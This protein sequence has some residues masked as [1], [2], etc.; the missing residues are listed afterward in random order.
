MTI[1]NADQQER[2]R[3]LCAAFG[4]MYGMSGDPSQVHIAGML[5]GDGLAQGHRQAESFLTPPTDVQQ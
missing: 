5:L 4:V 2:L 1:A 3:S